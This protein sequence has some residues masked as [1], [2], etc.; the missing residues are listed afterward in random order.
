MD[1]YQN[2]F[3]W[4]KF[5]LKTIKPVYEDSNALECSFSIGSRFSYEEM[6]RKLREDELIQDVK[7]IY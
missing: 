6:E 3:F 5:E 1:M 7:K 2:S 4:N